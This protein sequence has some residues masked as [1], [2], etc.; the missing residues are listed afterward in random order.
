LSTGANGLEGYVGLLPDCP[1]TPDSPCILSRG[2]GGGG[3]ALVEFF[4]PGRLG[5][6]RYH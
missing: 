1:D 5:D 3:T 2:S 6:P 4:V